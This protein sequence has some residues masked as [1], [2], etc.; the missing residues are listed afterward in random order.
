MWVDSSIPFPLAV[1]LAHD[2]YDYVNDPKY[3][4]ATTLLH[5]TRSIALEKRLPE[6]EEI[7]LQALIAPR[8]GTALHDS[9]EMVWKNPKA[10]QAAMKKLGYPQR[11]AERL[12]IH[13]EERNQKQ[14]MGYTIGGK[15]DMVV[16]GQL[17]DF[18]STSVWT[19]I[20]G[21][22]DKDYILQGSIY[23][24]LN[25][26]V[27]TSNS[28]VICFLFT[29]W[30]SKEATYK[31]NYPKSRIKQKEL[32]LLSDAEVESFLKKKLG[33]ITI[34]M[35]QKQ[36]DMVSCSDD[37]LWRS[38]PKFKYYASGDTSKRATRV[39]DTAQE[40]AACKAKNQNKGTVLMVPGEPKRCNYCPASP[41]CEQRRQM[42][43]GTDE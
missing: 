13:I 6:P 22:K 31:E 10:W 35:Q 32:M 16:N 36:E 41:I 43:G 19:W 5:P 39:F 9:I 27:I 30:S 8:M 1:W 25:P 17:F 23:K 42:L 33:D 15:F 40:A 20:N 26:G 12:D 14:F 28:I 29:D 37:E 7:D 21:D 24:W 11:L 18:K 2:E 3:I 4:S 38:Q 34:A